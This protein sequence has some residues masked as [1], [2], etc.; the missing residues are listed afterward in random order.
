MRTDETLLAAARDVDRIRWRLRR[1]VLCI[2]MGAIALNSD[3]GRLVPDTKLDLVV[4]P[5]GFMSRALHLWDRAGFAG[6]LQNQAYGYFFPMGPFFGIGHTLGL[7]PWV[8]QRLWWW[9]LL[10]LAFFGVIRLATRLGIGSPLTVTLAGLAYALSP[11]VLSVLGPVSAEA[12]PMC[13]APWVLAPLLCTGSVRRAAASSGLAVLAMGCVNAALVVAA[14]IP[15]VLWLATRRMAGRHIRLCGWWLLS[16]LCASLWWIVPLLLLGRYSPP[17]LGYIENSAITTSTTS[18]AE[19]LR[20]TADWLGY[21]PTSGWHAAWILLTQPVAILMSLLVMGIGAVG[22]LLNSMPHRRFLISCLLLGV[23]VMSAGFVGTVDGA[24]ASQVRSLLDGPLAPLRNVHK[25]DPMIRLPFVLGLAHLLS[26]VSWGQLAIERRVTRIASVGIAC[27]AILATAAPF[28]ALRVAATGTFA[29]IPAYWT[30]TAQWLDGHATSSRSLVVPGARYGYYI[31]GRPK[32]EPLQPLTSASWEVR[33]AVPMVPAG[34]IRMLD[35]IDELFISG[36]PTAGLAPF[37]SSNGIGY[38]VVRN[39]LDYAAADAPPP[40]QVHSVLLGSPGLTRVA[41]FGPQVGSEGDGAV[42]IDYGRQMSYPAVEIFATGDANTMNKGVSLVAQANLPAVVG[43]AESLLDLGEADLPTNAQLVGPTDPASTTSPA[44]VTDGNRR[45]ETTFGRNS[46]ASSQT[47]T[48]SDRKTIAKV[49]RDY[50]DNDDPRYQT[51][52]RY[53]GVLDVHASSAA[54]DASALLATTPGEQP[55][56]A[57]DGDPDTAWSSAPVTEPVGQWL[58]LDFLSPRNV[59]RVTVHFTPESAVTGVAAFTKQGFASAAVPESGTVSLDIPAGATPYLKLQIAQVAPGTPALHQVAVSEIEVDR[60]L[61]GRTLV[62]PDV[63]PTGT[64]VSDYVFSASHVGRDGCLFVERR[65]LCVPGRAVPDEDASGIDRTF[66]APSAGQFTPAVTVVPRAGAALDALIARQLNSE[67]TVSAS[68]RAVADP[69]AGPASVLDGDLQTGWVAQNTDPD[70][71]LTLSLGRSRVV[72]SLRVITDRTLA[73]T[74]PAFVTVRTKNSTQTSPIGSDG[75]VRITPVTGSALT[76]EFPAG[77]K[78]PVFDPAAGYPST[79]GVGVSEVEIDG[80]STVL[81]STSDGHRVNLGCGQGPA[82]KIDGRVRETAVVTTVS[83]L[84]ELRPM[85]VTLCGAKDVDLAQGG[86]RLTLTANDLFRPR[87]VRLGVSEPTRSVA[88]PGPIISSWSAA[89]A[90]IA[91]PTLAVPTVLVIAENQNAGWQARLG[92]QSLHRVTVNGWQQGY[93]IPAGSVGIVSLS[94]G[95]DRSYRIGMCVG[96][97]AALVLLIGFLVSCLRRALDSADDL[98]G[99][100]AKAPAWLVPA[101]GLGASILVGGVG[102]ALVFGA[103]AALTVLSGAATY[104]ATLAIRAIVIGGLLIAAVALYQAPWTST[105]YAAPTM[106]VQF[107]CLAVLMGLSWSAFLPDAQ[108]GAASTA[109]AEP[110]GATA[111]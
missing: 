62:V 7:P 26:V 59:G 53:L 18:L 105:H 67:I 21:L 3:A 49:Q 10:S 6:Q 5:W 98:P 66:A 96:L 104:R 57:V 94:F 27:V 45:R 35:A 58:Q 81:R 36:T 64:P 50:V 55:F 13:L 8:V 20:G 34:H 74:R 56:A 24:W 89:S 109:S 69:T 9:L 107:A 103:V 79:V 31:W 25:F 76:L 48:V 73:A 63:L 14:V 91:V 87:I 80:M 4:N 65:P 37:L 101:V 23:A 40:A 77:F 1:I 72:S 32:D 71:S 22:L 46:Q 17:F 61:V 100:G 60:L 70:P 43:G 95:P 12:L 86:H 84:R 16:V 82:L 78:R 97:I 33:D 42:S 111:S 51:V 90:Q 75:T 106:L 93:L 30:Q 47:L 102:G 15:T 19:T 88:V 92:G 44:I 29:E 41:S 52:A 85:Q 99:L 39:D 83:A 28:V 54:S 38:L 11:H 110:S 2:A 68:S 108:A